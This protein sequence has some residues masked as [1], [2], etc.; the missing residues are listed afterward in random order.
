MK[1]G[2][3]EAEKLRKAL[4]RDPAVKPELSARKEYLK[5]LSFLKKNAD[6][7][8]E[9]ASLVPSVP[10]PELEAY[11]TSS[12]RYQLG[13]RETEGL[14]RYLELGVAAGYFPGYPEGAIHV[15]AG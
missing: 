7:I 13:E 11:F 2:R 4:E 12:I 10:G 6:R 1:E 5:V 8:P 9:L 3:K 14:R 15:H